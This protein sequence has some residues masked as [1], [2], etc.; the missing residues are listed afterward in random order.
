SDSFRYNF[1]WVSQFGS[2]IA[3]GNLYPR[4]LPDSFEGLGSPAFYFYPPIALWI[5]GTLDA[6]GFSTLAAI[7]VTAWLALAASGMA[8]Y[9]WLKSRGTYPLVGALLYMVAPYHL[10]DFYVRGALAEFVAFIWLPLIALGI[11]RVEERRGIAT[12]ALSYAALILTHL[13][14]AMLT[15]FFLIAPLALHS[16]WR[17]RRTVAPLLGAGTGGIALAA[18]YLLPALTLQHHVAIDQLWQARFQPANWLLVGGDAAMIDWPIITAIAGLTVLAVGKRSVWMGITMGAA[19]AAVG[20]IPYLW[21]IQPF[22]SAQ[23]PWRLLSIIEFAA[24]TA[25]CAH[26][27]PRIAV[28]LGAACLAVAYISWGAFSAAFLANPPSVATL[29]RD[30]PDAPEYLPAGFDRSRIDDSRRRADLSPWRGVA[31]DDSIVVSRSGEVM[32]GRAAFPI[33]RVT[34]DGR[35]VRYRGPIIHFAAQPGTYHIERRLIWQEWTGWLLSLTAII[36]LGWTT[37]RGRRSQSIRR[38]A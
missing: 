28:A 26:R 12:L 5:A 9:A 38:A 7:N 37:V 35:E 10:M 19:A 15:T 23:F 36:L 4:W 3:Q 25:L 32:M 17:D 14:L 8:M 6:V 20:L 34:R 16:T 11:K 29:A 21:H 33:W 13:P 2:E 24:I 31:R 27:P 30:F 22:A 1:V 18:F